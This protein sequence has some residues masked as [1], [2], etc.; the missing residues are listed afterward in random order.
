MVQ[1]ILLTTKIITETNIDHNTF[2]SHYKLNLKRQKIVPFR[3]DTTNTNTTSITTGTSD[4]LT[5]IDA[6]IDSV[7]DKKNHDDVKMTAKKLNKDK[8]YLATKK[9]KDTLIIYQ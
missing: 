2:P 9:G 4:S 3:Y 8:G 7:K 5:T 1:P 6:V